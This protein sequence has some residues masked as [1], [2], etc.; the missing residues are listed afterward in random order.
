MALPTQLR[1]NQHLMDWD[2]EIRAFEKALTDYGNAKADL[3]FERALVKTRATID[4]PSLALNRLELIADADQQVHRFTLDFRAAE[5]LVTAKK[6]RLIWYAS[7]AD[8][9]RS[10][11]STERAESLLYSERGE[12]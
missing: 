9:L 5:A 3:E 7:V 6:S 10:E 12:G 1:L 4:H 2:V 11:V 8:A